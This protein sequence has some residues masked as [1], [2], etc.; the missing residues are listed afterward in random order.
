MPHKKCAN[1]T[2][3]PKVQRSAYLLLTKDTGVLARQRCSTSSSQKSKSV[4]SLLC[5][6]STFLKFS[7]CTTNKKWLLERC[8]GAVCSWHTCPVLFTLIN[9]HVYMVAKAVSEHSLIKQ[10]PILWQ[11]TSFACLNYVLF[12]HYILCAICNLVPSWEKT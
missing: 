4:L 12:R 3:Y 9:D 8:I 1:A 5:L 6:L 11:G 10:I 2:N 7:V